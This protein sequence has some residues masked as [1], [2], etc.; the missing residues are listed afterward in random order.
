MKKVEKCGRDLEW[1]NYNIFGNVRK[2]LAKKKELLIQA[3]KEAQVTGLNTQVRALKEEINWIGKHA[4]GAKD[5]KHCGLK[6]ETKIRDFFIAK[7]LRDSGKM[8]FVG[9]YMNQILGKWI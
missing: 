1:W 9:L 6:M 2:E 7:P 5:H 8:L 3:K 4:C